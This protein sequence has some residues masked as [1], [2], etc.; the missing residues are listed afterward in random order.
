MEKHEKPYAQKLVLMVLIHVVY[1]SKKPRSERRILPFSYLIR[2][3]ISSQCDRGRPMYSISKGT[4]LP[5]PCV[6]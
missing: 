5:R 3:Y 2:T 4:F 6:V 1:R